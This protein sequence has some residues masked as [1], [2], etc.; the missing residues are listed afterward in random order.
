[1]MTHS[2]S[3]LCAALMAGLLALPAVAAPNNTNTSITV[4]GYSQY[5]FAEDLK[6]AKQGDARAKNNVG[7]RYVLGV[8]GAAKDY[9]QAKFWLEQASTQGDATAQ[10]NLGLMYMQG[11][12]VE[13][14][15]T[16]A[17]TLYEQAA[18]QGY[19][20]AQYNLGIMYTNGFGIHQDYAK[21]KFWFEQAAAQKDQDA[22]NA[23]NLMRQHGL[24]Q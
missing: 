3:I 7:M 11:L 14:N 24:I 19:A 8:D 12:G 1:M 15:H 9:H 17:K 5:S 18:A 16:K 4:S 22:Q 2:R 23:L 21:A 20:N 10:N 6:R 13:K